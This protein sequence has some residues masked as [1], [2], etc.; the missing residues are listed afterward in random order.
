M[1]DIE[2]IPVAIALEEIIGIKPPFVTYKFPE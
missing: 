1:Q 2:E